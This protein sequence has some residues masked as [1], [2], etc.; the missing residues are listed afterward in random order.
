MAPL[1]RRTASTRAKRRRT[2]LLIENLERRNLMAVYTVAAGSPAG[3]DGSPN[4]PFATIS[5][6]VAVA[7]VNP[8]IDEIEVRPGTYN[9]SVSISDPDG[10][11]LR[12]DAQSRP[13]IVGTT[14]INLAIPTGNFTFE[15]LNLNGVVRAVSIDNANSPFTRRGSVTIRNLEAT[16]SLNANN[17]EPL[18]LNGL[19]ELIV[20]NVVLTNGRATLFDIN[21]AQLSQVS[22]N[23]SR[24]NA[25]LANYV[26]NLTVDG[27]TTS[28]TTLDG[29]RLTNPIRTYSGFGTRPINETNRITVINSQITGSQV[30]G[31]NASE[32]IELTVSNSKFNNNSSNGLNLSLASLVLSDTEANGNFIGVNVT[33]N[34]SFTGT[35]VTAKNNRSHGVNLA[36][37]QTVKLVGAELTGN[38]N[39]GLWVDSALGTVELSQ[40]N[41]SSNTLSGV[42]LTNN[43]QSISL[44]NV[45]TNDNAR[46]GLLF[47]HSPSS[48]VFP[49]VRVTGGQALRNGVASGGAGW[50]MGTLGSLVMV[51]FEAAQNGGYGLNLTGSRLLVDISTSNFSQNTVSTG[52]SGAGARFAGL[53]RGLTLT[54]VTSANNSGPGILVDNAIGKITADGLISTGNSVDGLYITNASRQQLSSLELTRSNLSSNGRSGLLS[55][56]QSALTISNTEAN[57]NGPAATSSSPYGAGI[58]I[59]QAGEG[60]T[61]E[62]SSVVGTRIGAY[63]GAG[64]QIVNSLGPTA[65]VRRVTVKDTVT[66]PQTTTPYGAGI[67]SVGS[68]GGL[69]VVD[70]V[71]SGN[72]LLDAVAGRASL[73]SSAKLNVSGSQ[74]LNNEGNTIYSPN[75]T[76]VASTIANSKGAIIQS[77]NAA[78]VRSTISGN[79]GVNG[80]GAGST[81]T[82][83]GTLSIDQSTITNNTPLPLPSANASVISNAGSFVIRNSVIAGNS[84]DSQA[85]SNPAATTS[86]GFNFISG[87]P[88][89][90]SGTATD[91]VGDIN[92]PIDAK[93]L[94][95]ADNGGPTLTHLPNS[96]SPL[97][98]SGDSQ[99]FGTDQ[100]GFPRPVSY[101]GRPQEIADI[102]ATELEAVNHAPIVSLGMNFIEGL[103]GTP[104]LLLGSVLDVDGNVQSVTASLGEVQFNADGTFEWTYTASDDLNTVVTITAVDSFGIIGTASFAV[105]MLNSAPVLGPTNVSV[106]YATRIATVSTQVTDAGTADVVTVT[107]YWGDGTVTETTPGANGEV[108]VSHQYGAVGEVKLDLIAV[109]DEGASSK[110]FSYRVN[111][112]P[113]LNLESRNVFANEGD[114]VT[115]TG[116][117]IDPESNIVA[118]E[119]SLGSAT[120]SADGTFVWT[121]DAIDDLSTIVNVVLRDSFGSSSL[122]QFN[123][124]VNNVA[125][126]LGAITVTLD[127]TRSAAIVRSTVT[128]PGSL[129]RPSVTINGSGY[130]VG[131]DGQ[132]GAVHLVPSAGEFTLEFIAWDKDLGR[133]ASRFVTMVM[134]GFVQDGSNILVYGSTAVDTVSFSVSK[135]QLIAS[136]NFAGAAIQVAFAASF[137]ET[138]TGYLGQG[139]DT[140]S[141]GSLTVPQFV[142]GEEGNDQIT[143]GSANDILVGGLGDDVLRGGLGGDL[144]FGGFGADQLFGDAGS[145][146]LVGGMYALERDLASLLLLRTAWNGS[147]NYQSRVNRLRSGVG[148]N[149]SGATVRLTIDLVT[150]DAIDQLFG[151][152]DS[153]WFLTN[154]ASE[155]RDSTREELRN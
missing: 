148:T 6:A 4:N 35:N 117:A 121:Y 45:V 130:L 7:R 132:F 141:G 139:N 80:E 21:N 110:G 105:L 114:K 118:I 152:R 16:S 44:N 131:D 142:Y 102:G 144:L 14:P 84:A 12:G 33:R 138:I 50:E 5:Q 70:S 36:G 57:Q 32:N 8:G 94:P 95:L 146:V 22:V 23:N 60:V 108:V 154:L 112:S 42:T 47:I 67:V 37:N 151:G 2:Q 3:G 93:L 41:A 120:I 136:G 11:V 124:T 25:L 59:E 82:S 53:E 147:G 96:D 133:S 122:T 73:Y 123:L 77:G 137:V 91:F 85:F 29:I 88:V 66:N 62:D 116:H 65:T 143:T 48:Q 34:G 75:L 15:N 90:W 55:F 1:A 129:D 26:S 54:T 115:L 13:T 51:G 155:V 19:N 79:L 153:D 86:N 78:I 145:D 111:T 99:L 52:V 119:T 71:F 100:R 31:L 63:S 98:D 17:W 30:N 126:T 81:I 18:Y 20:S 43:R 104:L 38:A 72:K 127:P 61:I 150:D 64:I 69:S 109:D 9:E 40:V 89:G 28:G 87:S 134:P 68:P 46:S 24:N 135:K 97:I 140:W 58:W 27:L 106:D 107:I 149:A 92:N 103:E 125:P 74:F 113:S 39:L 49:E 83:T 56:G 128:D 10:V 101:I 76:L